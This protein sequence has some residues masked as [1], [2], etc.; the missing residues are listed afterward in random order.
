MWIGSFY[1]GL[2]IWK[3]KADEM[4]IYFQNP[5]KNSIKGKIVRSIC[6]DSEGKIWFCTE[7]GW[8][9]SLDA[10][11]QETKAYQ[12]TEKLKMIE[13]REFFAVTIVLK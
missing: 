2:N 6:S 12:I 3:N 8:L 13:F 1:T 5:S 9:N 11:K 10:Q 7:D 4:A